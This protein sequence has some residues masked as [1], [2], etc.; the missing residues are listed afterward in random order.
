MG[1]RKWLVPIVAGSVVVGIGAGILFLG[2]DGDTSSNLPTPTPSVAPANSPVNYT[3]LACFD[4]RAV[5]TAVTQGSIGT[6]DL[7]EK[8]ALVNEDAQRSDNPAIRD[9]AARALAASSPYDD[10]AM[11]DA[12]TSFRE[13]CDAE[14]F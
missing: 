14:G 12:I 2:G 4:F 8:F 11:L 9:A 13:A 10:E 6:T 7:P 3:G 1:D 5:A